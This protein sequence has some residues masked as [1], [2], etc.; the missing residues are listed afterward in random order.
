MVAGRK[1]LKGSAVDVMYMNQ[2][3]KAVWYAAKVL[4]LRRRNRKQEYL[5]LAD[6]FKKSSAEWI[7]ASARR[8]RDAADATALAE[9][10][11]KVMHGPSLPGYLGGDEYTV[12]EIIGKRRHGSHV[13]Y[14]VKW[15]GWKDPTWEPKNFINSADVKEYEDDREAEARLAAKPSEIT[16]KPRVAFTVARV[17]EEGASEAVADAR[18]DD[19]AL[20]RKTIF[21]AGVAELQK[22]KD[23]RAKKKFFTFSPI[24]PHTYLALRDSIEQV[25]EAAGIVGGV[26]DI[27]PTI[28]VRGTSAHVADRFFVTKHALLREL[29]GQYN[30]NGIIVTRVNGTRM[31]LLPSIAFKFQ[32]K[33]DDDTTGTLT[34]SAHIGGLV[35]N[36]DS[37][38]TWDLDSDFGYSAAKAKE[39]KKIIAA[40]VRRLGGVSASIRDFFESEGV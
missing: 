24:A 28:G 33:R 19:A 11:Q 21:K 31:V 25:A 2:K 38:P 23:G 39:L 7:A 30:D 3:K 12:E 37:P 36:I 17:A 1:R 20:L 13:K 9:D 27:E 15:L 10:H 5:V 32:A 6:H 26:S 40:E 8:L 22:E 29:V 18:R 14:K 16:A 35:P 4:D 34:V